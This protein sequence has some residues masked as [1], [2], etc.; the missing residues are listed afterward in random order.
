V[1]FWL[2][3]E[4]INLDQAKIAK[5]TRNS[6]RLRDLERRG[7]HPLSEWRSGNDRVRRFR[8]T[9]NHPARFPQQW[10]SEPTVGA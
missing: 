6:L 9:L 7:Y 2:H 1:P 8:L 3:N 4:F 5:S 10:L